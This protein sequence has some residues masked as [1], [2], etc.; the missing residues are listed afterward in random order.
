[1]T[2][3][4]ASPPLTVGLVCPYS[5]AA[6]GGVQ[7][8]LLELAGWLTRQGHRV[9]LLAPD[10]PSEESLARNGLPRSVHTS[11][12]AGIRVRF[13]GSVAPICLPRPAVVRRW[14]RRTR[15]DVLHVHEPMVPGPALLATVLAG[16][17]PVVGTFHATLSD[18]RLLRLGRVAAAVPGRLSA[19][20]A[21]SASARDSAR[22][23]WGVEPAVLPNGF[24]REEFLDHPPNGATAG[25]ER[26]VRV[27]FLGRTDDPRKGL[28]VFRAAAPL[29]G[30]RA[31]AELPGTEV[32]LVV[33]GP[34]SDGAI[35]AGAPLRSLGQLSDRQRVALLRHSRVFVAPHTAGESFGLVLAEA[36][37]AGA[38]VVAAD[39]PAFSALLEGGRLG[40]LFDVAD[41]VALADT[42]LDVLTGRRSG[43]RDAAREA[44]RAWGWDRIGP[45]LLGIYRDVV[46]RPGTRLTDGPFIGEPF[47]P[48]RHRRAQ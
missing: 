36:M 31:P 7:N 39:L 25:E 21:V 44:T 23:T 14:L 40:H 2:G 9:H 48:S 1:M 13:N 6:I 42:V 16:S 34:G 35:G 4:D 24:V 28:E 18:S 32:E 8:Q 43:R 10:R 11:A 19:A 30:R 38:E 46:V 5:L 12:G 22:H 15:P 47:W 29:I 26:T 33:A 27:T 17:V 45:E 3:A 41:P 37:A 20:T